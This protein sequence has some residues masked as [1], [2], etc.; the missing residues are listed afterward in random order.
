MS[1]S[2]IRKSTASPLLLIRVGFTPGGGGVGVGVVG[3]V[4]GGG[5]GEGERKKER[6]RERES[7]VCGGVDEVRLTGQ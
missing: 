6:E 5:G 3:V 4:V 7:S 2:E 1:S